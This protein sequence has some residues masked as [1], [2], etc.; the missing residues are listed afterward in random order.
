MKRS[1]QGKATFHRYT[2]LGVSSLF[3]LFLSLSQPHRVHHFFES[4]GYSHDKPR[5]NSD[6]HHHDQRPNKPVQT[7]CV[8]QSVA[9]NCHLGQAALVELPFVESHLELFTPQLNQQVDLFT[10]F[11]V[12]QRAPP[13]DTLIS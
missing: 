6:N 10:S 12:F 2:A 1:S 4:D 5:A 9:Q 3:L 13:K 8:V 11:S 7:D